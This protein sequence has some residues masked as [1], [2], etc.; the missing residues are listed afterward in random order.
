[1]NRV[2][3]KTVLRLAAREHARPTDIVSGLVLHLKAHGRTKLLPAILRDIRTAH[4][5]KQEVLPS[6]ETASEKE[7]VAA[8]KAAVAEGMETGKA[9]VNPSLIRGWRAQAGG[10][11]IDRSAKRSLI[12]LYRNIITRA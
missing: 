11:L 4:L 5:R 6:L 10:I 2:Y 3:A 1:M 8:K 7:S 12:E 9:I